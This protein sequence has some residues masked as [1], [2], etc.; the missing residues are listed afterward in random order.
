MNGLR[1]REKLKTFNFLR[2]NKTG[3]ALKAIRSLQGF[4]LPNTKR[5][6]KPYRQNTEVRA[7]YSVVGALL[8]QL[9]KLQAIRSND[10]P[11]LGK[12][13]DLVRIAVVKM[14]R[15]QAEGHAYRWRRWYSALPAGYLIVFSKNYSRRSINTPDENQL[16]LS[17]IS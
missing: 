9:E 5:Q 14:Q 17:E 10:I 11:V 1:K 4:Q 13:A 16:Q 15:L 6:K 2:R 8:D 12:F 7:G 3:N